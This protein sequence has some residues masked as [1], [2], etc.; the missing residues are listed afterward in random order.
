MKKIAIL[1]SILLF[2]GNLVANAQTKT[3][4]GTVTSSEDNLPIPG[5]SV[6]VKGTTLGTITNVNGEYELKVPQDATTLV[7][8]F[9][10]MK[11]QDVSIAGKDV[12]DL[13]MQPE[14]IGVDEVVVTALGIQR[15]KRELGYSTVNINS[16]ELTQAKSMNVASSLQGKVPGLNISSLNSGVMED[17]KINL[18]GIRSLTGSNNPMLLLDG[19]P[20]GLGLLNT[21]NP[22]DIESINVLKGT[23]AAAVYG[24]D[25]R[26]GVIVVT[27]K[28]GSKTDIPD[29][30]ISN[31]T[32]FSNVSFFPKFQTQFGSGGSGSYI[33]YENWSWGPEFDGS[34]VLLGEVLENGNEQIVKYAA[35]NS[36]KEFFDTGIVMQNDISYSAKNFYLSLQDA[37]NNGVMPDDENRRT[38]VRMNVSQTY[39]KFTATFNTNYIYQKY[40]VFDNTAMGD[41]Y[42]ANNVGLNGGLMNLIFSTPAQVPLTSY[43]DFVNNEFAQYNNYFNR[44]GINPYIA[45]DTWRKEGKNQNLISSLDLKLSPT[46]WLDLNYRAAVTHQSIV[47]MVTGKRLVTNSY[48]AGRG[49]DNVPQSVEN[50]TYVGNRFSSE[51]YAN[52]HK[53]FGDFKVNVLGGT[54]VREVNSR[55]TG[56]NASNLVIE[57]LF[58]VSARPGEL[59]GESTESRSR[60]FSYYGSAS[61]NYKNFA[62]I[63]VTGRN[64]KTSVLDPS[65][66]SYFYPGVSGSLVLTDAIPALKSEAFGFMKLRASWNKT[67][68]ADINPYLLSAT[69]SQ[70]DGFPFNG[71]PGYSADDTSYDKYLEPEFIESTEFGFE[72]SMLRDRINLDATYY[73]QKNT[74]QI[75]NVRVPRSTGYTFAYVNAASFKNYGFETQLKLTPLVQLG[76]WKL[77]FTANYSY[78]NSEVLSIYQDLQELSIGGYVMAANQAVVGE[79]AFI[80]NASDYKRD[81]EGHVIVDAETGM[82]LIDEVNKKFGRTMPMHIIGLNPS[83]H[84]KGLTFSALFEYKGGHYNF[85]LIG[86][87]M[88]WTGTSEI[89]GANH[90]ERFVIPNSVY[91]DPANP[92]QYITNTNVTITD[93]ND[94][95]TSDNYR[96]V[97]S[98]FITSAAAWRFRELAITYDL[99]ASLLAKQDIVKGVTVGFVGRNLALWLPKSN[100]YSDPDYRGNNSFLT[101]NISGISNAT[102]NPPVRTLGGTLSV[103]F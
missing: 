38:G 67:G 70:G 7:F 62:N 8:S 73:T 87:E 4:T 101:G 11:T 69:F 85:N 93:V 41:Y 3:I 29:I 55:T 35:N 100:V 25:A 13:L 24:P 27:T 48:G 1:L 81:G 72:I 61:L 53:T 32:Q 89:T 97:A 92:G 75:V 66:N 39:K 52:L 45:L 46:D 43:K 6:A 28:S 77:N 42:A 56:V 98:N 65:N 78:N 21:I 16:E 34:D 58:N 14:T 33:P 50:S 26:N 30:V 49:L 76:E 15:Q 23:S 36:R 12:I 5:V 54:Y 82:P 2:M 68:N 90:R 31:T 103:R 84:W 63:E 18:R 95:F 94:F 79:P 20:V 91:E 102:V 86:N 47:T 96:S 99:P 71:M 64:D 57:G 60:L 44:Y 9:V 37:K 88:A 40:D 80:F 51:F 59:G 83:I 74:N 22:N 10:G 17:V 19:V